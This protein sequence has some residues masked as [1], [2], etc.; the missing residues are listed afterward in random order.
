LQAWPHLIG[1]KIIPI[2]LCLFI[3][4]LDEYDGIGLDL[5]NLLDSTAMSPN[6][7]VCASSR[8]EIVYE[9]AFGKRPGLR[10]QGLTKPDIELFVEERLVSHKKMQELIAKEPSS[11]RELVHEIQEAANGVFLWVE[12][13]VSSLLRGLGNSDQTSDLKRRLRLLP[14]TLEKLFEHMISRVDEAYIEESSQLFQLVNEGTLRTSNLEDEAELPTI[15][16]LLFASSDYSHLA[17]SAND[18]FLSVDQMFQKCHEMNK[19]LMSRC[20]GLIETSKKR[21]LHSAPTITL[22]CHVG[23]LHRTVRD[24][25]VMPKT[26]QILANQAGTRF[27][28]STQIL[29]SC[30]LQL[31]ALPGLQGGDGMGGDYLINRALTFAKKS[32]EET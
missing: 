24:F 32:E 29:R 4:G 31:K 2:K 7:K 30:I 16:E 26:Q 8:P 3:D 25:L 12:I 22:D 17:E 5:V 27:N 21:L 14:K 18:G 13:V 19:R 6:I 10:L 28:A 11:T 15:I 23:Y 1:Q 20:G 9:D